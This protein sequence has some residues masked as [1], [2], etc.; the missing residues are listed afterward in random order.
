MHQ[1][2]FYYF[3]ESIIFGRECKG[4]QSVRKPIF[5]LGGAGDGVINLRIVSK[6]W[7]RILRYHQIGLIL[8]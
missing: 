4:T 5:L 7:Y 6:K 3:N 1:Q 8:S 2:P